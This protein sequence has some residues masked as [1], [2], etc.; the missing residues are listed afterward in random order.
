MAL[1]P[2]IYAPDPRLKIK[3]RPVET[4][5]QSVRDLTRDM[6]ETMYAAPGIGLSAP[7]IGDTR[8]ILVCDVTREGEDRQPI[9]LVNP[10]I[11]WSSDEL[12]LAEEGCLSLPD[13]FAEIERPSEVRI[14]YL[15]QQGESQEMSADG[16]LAACVQ[17]EMD[18]LEGI[19]FVDYLSPLKRNIILRKMKKLKRQK[20]AA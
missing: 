12:Y 20:E 5:D 9:Q 2:I 16:L 18:H 4:V 14:R 15:D 6:L 19:L 13:H 11:V 10:E 1:L 3:C 17:H 8:R 7:Q